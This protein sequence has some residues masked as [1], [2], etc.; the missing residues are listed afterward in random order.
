MAP[1]GAGEPRSFQQLWVNWVTS[2]KCFHPLSDLNHFH[3]VHIK[4]NR[5]QGQTPHLLFEMTMK[6]ED[7]GAAPGAGLANLLYNF[8]ATLNCYAGNCQRNIFKLLLEWKTADNI[9]SNIK[10][11]VIWGEISIVWPWQEAAV[12]S[13]T[14]QHRAAPHMWPV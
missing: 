6:Q 12:L 8:T 5:L 7:G 3:G 10:I 4:K 2:E 14:A 1:H 9:Q 13:A 11:R